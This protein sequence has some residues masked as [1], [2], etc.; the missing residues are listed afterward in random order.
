MTQPTKTRGRAGAGARG[1]GP[2]HPRRRLILIVLI[3]A[4]QTVILD[5]SVLNVALTTLARPAPRGLGA[6]V[7]AL[8]WAVNAYTLVFAGLLFSWGLLADRLGRKRT[9]TLGLA[10]F[11]LA[12]LW[13]A[14]AGSP[15][16]LIAARAALGVGGAAVMPSTLAV[17]A[18]VFP[19]AEH[20]RA[21]GLWSGSV[22]L[23]IAAGPAVG[24]AL[25][26]SYWWGSVFL[27]NV[28]IVAAVL[29]A[30]ILVVPESRNPDPGRLDPA[31]VA[32]LLA[33]LVTFVY[34]VIRGG[35]TGAW[36]R[37][38]VWGPVA[39]GLLSTTVFV[40]WE[41]RTDHPLLDVRL[42]R[43]RAFS[44]AVVSVAL[45][46]FVLLGG[47][48]A[49]TFYLQSVRGLSPLRAGLWSL[50][51]AASQLVFS[52]LSPAVV[53]RFGA[54]A[55]AGAGLF[56]VAAAFV[57]Y[58]WATAASP[59]WVYGL[60]AFVQ[61]SF[62]ANV[63]PPATT[64]I[65]AAL[66][67]EQAGIG[68]SVNSTVRQVGGALGVAVLGTVLTTVYRRRIEPLA[69]ANPGVPP[70]QARELSGSVQATQSGVGRLLA[71]HPQA[72]RL[73]APADDAFIHAM[74]VTTLTAAGVLMVAGALVLAWIPRSPAASAGPVERAAGGV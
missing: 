20:G 46:Y 1:D 13:C 69:A 57:G 41:L 31:G 72:A 68:S 33:G 30:V 54:R 52:P 8:E 17:L 5:T 65:M 60:I 11:G 16:E 61:G 9:L 51:F 34:G 45:S 3:C 66:P 50:P 2:G 6:S 71:A 14:G 27:V 59:V 67:R 58:Q 73:L 47:M 74:H 42:L 23:A 56:G 40:L 38:G 36:T 4:L 37:P 39:A 18:D 19:R 44:A 26:G 62:T 15:G 48:F 70:G 43:N 10:V 64:A 35:D 7:S 29:A 63:T 12:S 28:P 53:R 32:L 22:G 21:I 55:T 25:L 49:F 24:G